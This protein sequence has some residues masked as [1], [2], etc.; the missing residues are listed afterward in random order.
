MPIPKTPPP[1]RKKVATGPSGITKLKVFSVETATGA[2]AYVRAASVGDVLET[3]TDALA[4]GHDFVTLVRMDGEPVVI[5]PSD[6]WLVGQV[7]P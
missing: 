3:I 7:N 5:R 4:A 1:Q 6:V 2:S